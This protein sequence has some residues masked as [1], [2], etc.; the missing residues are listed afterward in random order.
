[1]D[2]RIIDVIK[3]IQSNLDQIEEI[4]SVANEYY[5]RYKGVAFSIMR[6][7]NRDA[8]YGKY[9]F[10]VYPLSEGLT[11]NDIAQMSSLGNLTEPEMVSYNLGDFHNDP[12]VTKIF[13]QLYFSLERKHSNMDDVF[14][15]ILEE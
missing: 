3:K 6:A 11:L 8:K 1:M 12:E 10:Y 4:H 5:F 14:R 2:P 9:S 15:K 7:F 13:E